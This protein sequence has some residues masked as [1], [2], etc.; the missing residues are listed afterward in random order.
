MEKCTR[1]RGLK[2]LERFPPQFLLLSFL[3]K[4]GTIELGRW[5]IVQNTC[6][7]SQRTWVW[8]PQTH[9]KLD[10]VAVCVCN[11]STS[12]MRYVVGR[13]WEIQGVGKPTGLLYAPKQETLSPARRKA[14]T[15]PGDCPLASICALW[16]A[17]AHSYT[18]TIHT[19]THTEFNRSVIISSWKYSFCS[20]SKINSVTLTSIA[21]CISHTHTY[22]TYEIA[23]KLK[24]QP[25]LWSV[26]CSYVTRFSQNIVFSVH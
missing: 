4:K 17:C 13:H 1:T 3:I 19:Y 23:S 16:H 26:F 18:Y 2:S 24:H 6:G 14:T 25:N 12:I 21:L 5:F 15:N 20:D 8:I 11:H 9:I 22:V 10:T 7:S